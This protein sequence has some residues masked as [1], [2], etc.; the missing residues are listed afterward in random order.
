[1]LD[2]E[3][4]TKVLV[5]LE[6][7]EV[8]QAAHSRIDAEHDERLTGLE[9]TVNGNGQTG[10]AEEVR[11]LKWRWGLLVA[12]VAIVASWLPKFL[13]LLAKKIGG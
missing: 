13:Y 12:G 10:L 4:K 8:N 7:I 1:M 2:E 11:N 5:T 3:F 9:H 6:R